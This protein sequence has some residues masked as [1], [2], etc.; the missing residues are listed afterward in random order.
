MRIKNKNKKLR[1]SF[2]RTKIKFDE[3]K[4]ILIVTSILLKTHTMGNTDIK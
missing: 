2:F 1:I 3:N 4:I